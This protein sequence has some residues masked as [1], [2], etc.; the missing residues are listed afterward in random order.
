MKPPKE[1]IR[2]I[3]QSQITTNP[4]ADERI[5]QDARNELA[6]RRQKRSTPL[7]AVKRKSILPSRW[8]MLSLAATAMLILFLLSPWKGD[9]NGSI[10]WADVQTQ[11][12][13]VRSVSLKAYGHTEYTTGKKITI[14]LAGAT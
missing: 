1:L 3:Q 6:K 8:A 4:E 10:S 5:L 12:E 7:D 14:I 11:L 9:L 2:L 13:Q